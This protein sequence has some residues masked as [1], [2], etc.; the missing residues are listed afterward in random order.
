MR[1]YIAGI[2]T[3]HFSKQGN[4][5]RRMSPAAKLLRDQVT[6]MLES[7]HYI[8]KGNYVRRIREDGAKVFLDSGAF[9]AFSLGVEVSIAAYAE[10]V[11]EHQDI[12][13]MASVLDAIGD[14]EGTYHNQKELERRGV[15]VLPCFHFGEPLELCEHYVSNYPYITLGGMVPIPNAKLEPWLDEVW[16]RVLTDR[17]GYAR[18]KVHGFGMTSRTLMIKY[19]WFSVDSSSW[20]Q[21]ASNGKVVFP[22]VDTVVDISKRSPTVHDFGRHFDN[23]PDITRQYILDLL[24]YYGLTLEEV[25]DIHDGRWALDCF[26]FDRLGK[27]LGDDHWRRPFSAQQGVLF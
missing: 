9:S 17:D 21:I 18:C 27:L 6:W 12:I 11:K 13:D 2:F 4:L 19:P 14:P 20:V 3:S 22:E 25:R 26:T 7:Y 23:M 16:D 15:E 10:F 5:Y 1:L 24:H 8:H